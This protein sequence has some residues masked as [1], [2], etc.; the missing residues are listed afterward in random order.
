MISIERQRI[1]FMTSV[2][3]EALI[4]DMAIDNVADFAR[5]ISGVSVDTNPAIAD[6]SGQPANSFR[7]R[8]FASEPLYNGFQAGRISS[9]EHIGRV[10]VSKGPNSVLYGQSGGGGIINF[11]PKSPRFDQGHLSTTVGFGN[12][13]FRRA[14][15][16]MGGPVSSD[17][18]G[19]IAFRLGGSGQHYER[20]Q[21]FF[22]NQSVTL[23]SA[24]SWI[25]NQQVKLDVTAEYFDMDTVPSRTAAFV[26]VGS[27]EDRVIDPFNRQRNDRNFSY[28]GP[29]SSNSFETVVV[30]GYLTAKLSDSITARFGGIYLNRDTDIIRFVGAYGLGTSESASSPFE[31]EDNALDRKGYKVDIL[32]Q[33]EL[34]GF[35]FD[36]IVG[37]EK[38]TQ[39]EAFRQ[40]RT[41]SYTVTIPFARRT[42]VSDWPAPPPLNEFVNLR[43]IA[44]DDLESSNIRFTQIITTPDTRGNLLWGMSRGEGKSTTTNIVT[45][46]SDSFDGSGN[47]YTVGSTYQLL[48]RNGHEALVF[49]NYST[50]FLIQSGNQ[51]DPTIFQGFSS[52][53]DLRDFVNSL[54]PNAADP[55][56]GKG[57]EVGAR[58][59]FFENQA[60]FS[61]AYFDQSRTNIGRTFF[62]R[63]N[64]VA[65]EAS[66]AV[67]GTFMLASGEENSK[68][69]DIDLDWNVSESLTLTLG[70]MFSSGKVVSNDST[71]EEVGFGL[72]RSPENM[73]NA[74]AR[75]RFLEGSI[76]NGLTLGFGASYASSTRIAPSMN[77]VYRISDSYVDVQALIRY[78]FE[79]GGRSHSISLNIRNLMDR[80]W[81]D[82]ANWLSEPRLA[83]I[84]YTI[85]W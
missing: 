29:Y 3:N 58:F 69:V 12:Q 38:Y 84:H 63:E 4:N 85:D 45:G 43:R 25:P 36:S 65:G 9:P 24:M 28:N 67:L 40:I 52:V 8:G 2:I 76:M 77:D 81:V 37:Y 62:V 7:V 49:A 26:S 50:S 23:F 74:W 48:K 78:G 15:F 39:S 66:E 46:Q 17:G 54:R 31:K 71:P 42:Q 20:D 75:Y 61:I 18:L 53:D 83:R 10:E 79:W 19:E 32:H 56:E 35:V 41:D 30:S 72:V 21:V 59:S 33:A 11:I 57:F 60:I 51:Q 27:G 44:R 6:E 5:M 80:E 64:L 73:I 34:N 1:P 55:E 70:A 47:T 14:S 82:E 68:G 13:S 22:E 16:D